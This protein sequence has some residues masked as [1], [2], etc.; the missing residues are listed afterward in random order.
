[1]AKTLCLR[2]R[3]VFHLAWVEQLRRRKPFSFDIIAC[4]VSQ[5]EFCISLQFT[6]STESNSQRQCEVNG[7]AFCELMHSTCFIRCEWK[8]VK[9]HLSTNKM[10]INERNDEMFV[11]F[12]VVDRLRRIIDLTQQTL[13][14]DIR[15]MDCR[16]TTISIL[17]RRFP[18]WRACTG[19]FI[20]T[21][22]KSKETDALC[23]VTSHTEKRVRKKI[24]LFWPNNLPASAL[25]SLQTRKVFKTNW[26]L[27]SSSLAW[28]VED[29]RI[30][31]IRFRFRCFAFVLI[32]NWRKESTATNL[33]FFALSRR[34][35]NTFFVRI[36]VDG[37]SEKLCD[38]KFRFI[39]SKWN[40]N[41]TKCF[42]SSCSSSFLFWSRTKKNRLLFCWCIFGCSIFCFIRQRSLTCFDTK[43]ITIELAKTQNET[44]NATAAGKGIK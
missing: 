16:L 42:S 30:D 36:V 37:R 10:K 26:A 20:H 27:T 17:L 4:F 2:R 19:T 44:W 12:S 24:Y 1:M 29:I 13:T 9:Q 5:T 8:R 40:G 6:L 11:V 34:F 7:N 41:T 3:W 39:E 32:L 33:C 35:C 43:H 22:M 31:V 21:W 14:W 18:W 28:V 38:Y 15:F 23:V 25:M